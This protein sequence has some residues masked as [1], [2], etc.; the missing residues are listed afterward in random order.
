M[1]QAYFLGAGKTY[2]KLQRALR[3]YI[4]DD[5]W[6]C[7]CAATSRPFSP[8]ATGKRRSKASTTAATRY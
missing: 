8:P 5:A 7:L 1:R 6:D 3:V 4:G 2:V